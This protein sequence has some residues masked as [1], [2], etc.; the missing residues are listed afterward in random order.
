MKTSTSW[1]G[2]YLVMS[3]IHSDTSIGVCLWVRLSWRSGCCTIGI[4]QIS[5]MSYTLHLCHST[6]PVSLSLFS[7]CLTPSSPTDT[8]WVTMT[9]MKW[10]FH[11][12]CQRINKKI[13]SLF[14]DSYVIPILYDFKKKKKQFLSVRWK[15]TRFKTTLD[16]PGF[17]FMYKKKPHTFFEIIYFILSTGKKTRKS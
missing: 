1:G 6:S 13:P 5:H 15:S 4:H 2:V 10:S 7:S 9:Q 14:T 17:H 3:R 12:L 11:Y 16:P 8:P